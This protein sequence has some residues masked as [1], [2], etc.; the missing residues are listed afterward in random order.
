MCWRRWRDGNRI[1]ADK[2]PYLRQIV[3]GVGNLRLLVDQAQVVVARIV[4]AV[5]G[6]AVGADGRVARCGDGGERAEGVVASAR[7]G[8]VRPTRRAEGHQVA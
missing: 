6:E 3:A 5:A 2:P 8:H 1:R 7:V 4:V